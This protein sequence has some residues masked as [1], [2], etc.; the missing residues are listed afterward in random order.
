MAVN[1]NP[2][3]ITDLRDTCRQYKGNLGVINTSGMTTFRDLFSS[4][5]FT[6]WT[7]DDFNGIDTWNTSNVTDM[8][9][10]FY[11]C[12]NFNQDISKWNVSK[13]KKCIYMFAS[14]TSFNRQLRNWSFDSLTDIK[15]MFHGCSSLTYYPSGF[16]APL[17]TDFSGVFG[18]CTSLTSDPINLNWNMPNVNKYTNAFSGS[19]ITQL[20]KFWSRPSYFLNTFSECNNLTTVNLGSDSQIVEAS[21][22]FK[23]CRNLSSAIINISNN[24]Y[25]SRTF[26][27]MFEGCSNLTSVSGTWDIG[28]TEL[29]LYNAFNG[30]SNLTTIPTINIGYNRELP[31]SARNM[32]T[33]CSRLRTVT[34][35]F[36]SYSYIDGASE[37]FKGCSSLIR[38]DCKF[39]KADLTSTFEGC[40][41][42]TSIDQSVLS[43]NPLVCNKTFKG[44]SSLNQD[45]SFW[46][47]SN[48]FSYTEMFSGCTSY[49]KD[50]S[51]IY[52]PYGSDF[53]DMFTNCPLPDD[54]KP[55]PLN[56]T[57]LY[58]PRTKEE[59]KALCDDP[60][61]D[62]RTID[63]S[64]I[65]D[66]S[67]LFENG[68]VTESRLY[69][70]ITWNTSNVTTM[71]GMFKGCSTY[72]FLD[73]TSNFYLE[74]L[75]C[76]L[77]EDMSEFFMDC[78][79]NRQYFCSTIKATNQFP[80]LKNISSMYENN[81]NNECY[82]KNFISDKIEYMDKTFK[83]TRYTLQ[84]NHDPYICKN[85]YWFL[86]NLIS[87]NEVFANNT[88]FGNYI[89]DYFDT[90][91]VEDVSTVFDSS[92]L[93]PNYVP[94]WFENNIPN[95]FN[96][97]YNTDVEV[98]LASFMNSRYSNRPYFILKSNDP[99]LSITKV[100]TNIY[101]I[102]CSTAKD[103]KA[104]IEY[105]QNQSFNSNSR[106][107]FNIKVFDLSKE[108]DVKAG[109][110]ESVDFNALYNTLI[111][112]ITDIR[113]SNIQQG[114]SITNKNAFVYDIL[115]DST[116]TFTA[117]ITINNRYSGTITVNASSLISDEILDIKNGYSDTINF[118]DKYPG[119]DVSTLI[120]TSDS[121]QLVV[122]KTSDGIFNF[123]PL[124][125][126]QFTATV[127][128]NNQISKVTVN[129]LTGLIPYDY[130][131][132]A[133]KY[134]SI[135]ITDIYGNLDTNDIRIESD[136]VDNYNV[137]K[138]NSNE[139]KLAS[140]TS[141]TF[142][143][144]IYLNN[145]ENKITVNATKFLQ[146]ETRN[147][148]SNT[149]YKFNLIDDIS[150]SFIKNYSITSGSVDVI[151]NAL[152][153][154]AYTIEAINVGIYNCILN[155][156]GEESNLILNVVKLIQDK[157]IFIYNRYYKLN[158]NT[159]YPNADL[160]GLKVVTSSNI[161]KIQLTNISN[162]IYELSFLE[163][164]TYELTITLGKTTSIFTLKVFFIDSSNPE[165]YQY[166]NSFID[167]L[168]KPQLFNSNLYIYQYNQYGGIEWVSKFFSYMNEKMK[169]YL[170][171]IYLWFVLKTN[172]QLDRSKMDYINDE[173]YYYY[174][175]F[176]EKYFDGINK[177]F[178]SSSAIT[179]WDNQ[180]SEWNDN[181]TRW[182]DTIKTSDLS[183]NKF[184]CILRYIKDISNKTF[185]LNRFIQ[186]CNEFV[187]CDVTDPADK[188]ELFVDE[189]S[190]EN[191]SSIVIY[192]PV[193]SDNTNILLSMVTSSYKYLMP[194]NEITIRQKIKSKSK[195]SRSRTKKDK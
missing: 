34:L 176:L 67:Y 50:L 70:L 65:T 47:S 15:F 106:R 82:M 195:S 17:L 71:K 173:K 24:G 94:W 25:A 88:H 178:G 12:S 166:P 14:C 43:T 188:I 80:S 105:N 160:T 189:T 170:D 62:L 87:C 95:S 150:D 140:A 191:P 45:F 63:T 151:A 38:V 193:I 165:I 167:E 3:S 32:F 156:N 139:Y 7:N 11:R 18:D 64:L 91:N 142:T 46:N 137:I 41:S 68:T 100:S 16:S 121:D 85:G 6:S 186:F 4:S 130:Q 127:N 122:T 57:Y 108:I 163:K 169:K 116:G 55:H 72:T 28:F 84:I 30:C 131:H 164:G 89:P 149:I 77:V 10:T 194:M 147:I 26:S 97:L 83:N 132:T 92:T 8:S 179:F 39:N 118:N 66:M 31:V 53:T 141:G 60:S 138:V 117:T 56:T 120:I 135:I 153:D 157:I 1:L 102:R 185:N 101:R 109:L 126:G 146:D 99:D 29:Y 175:N 136:D 74:N 168:I 93:N 79:N 40:S 54:K 13:V 58:R 154:N 19:G 143:A 86:P 144:T 155:I 61:I 69:N 152:P 48:C 190:F 103:I 110:I 52:L 2:T 20:T 129:G 96:I 81:I 119:Y 107:L 180:G 112:S 59:L 128:L 90:S 42:L 22:M 187:N 104:F 51:M 114:L 184:K 23:D 125:V 171:Y 181:K 78:T 183:V 158:F 148:S 111:P 36:D 49:N 76:P 162:G 177:A 145:E 115:T 133:V 159:M 27:Y 5:P 172:Q 98:N 73:N 37:M 33:G 113:F 75:Y 44:C 174:I 21:K 124:N 35:S 123:K 9:N 134:K 192:S 182:D 161:D